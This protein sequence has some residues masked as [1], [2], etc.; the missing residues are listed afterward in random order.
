MTAWKALF[1]KEFR[2]SR[3]WIYFNLAVIFLGAIYFVF[4]RSPSI[5]L[6]SLT[7]IIGIHILYLPVW[8]IYSLFME[9]KERAITHWY[10]LPHKGGILITSK[11]AAGM[12][13]MLLSI[14]VSSVLLVI[15]YT[16][17]LPYTVPMIELGSL[18]FIHNYWG[19]ILGIFVM[20]I[21]AGT[22]C[23]CA[24]LIGASVPKFKAVWMISF[25]LLPGII[26]ILLRNSNLYET[27]TGWGRITS[28]SEKWLAPLL[29]QDYEMFQSA[30]VLSKVTVFS[31]GVMGPQLLTSILLVWVSSILL[32]R[33]VQI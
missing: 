28:S 9:W 10:G 27:I 14:L 25:L 15:L 19:V 4:F 29:Q 18:W 33:Y 3:P 7:V 21:Y 20:G 8:L 6:Y 12:A 2:A 23:L 11:F 16:Y 5:V 24:L 26:Q 30:T 1:Y 17:N 31:A 32:D 13:M 22:Q